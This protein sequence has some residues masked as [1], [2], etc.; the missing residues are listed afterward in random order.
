MDGSQL[1]F[2]RLDRPELEFL[3]YRWDTYS[4]LLILYVLGIGSPTHPIPVDCWQHWKL[5]L[6]KVGENTYVGGGPLFIHQ[7]SQAW[8]DLRDRVAARGRLTFW[9]R[10]RL[11]R[12]FG[13]RHSRTAGVFSSIWRANSQATP[14][15]CGAS[16]L[17]T[18]PMV[19]P[20]GEARRPH[21]RMDGTVVPS[22]AAGS[23]MFTPDICI[24]AMRTMLLK[25]GKSIYGRYG[26]ADAFNPGS[27]MDEPVRHR[28][29]CRNHVAQRGKPADGQRVAMVHAQSGTAAR[30]GDGGAGQPPS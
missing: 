26:F 7:Y 6:V 13:G 25:Y 3:P 30:A 17:P 29:R 28:N 16:P 12:E 20:T 9:S 24:P 23:L 18:A 10:H 27:G 4:E 22:A 15:P 14:R 8:V 21:P 11:F 1:L 19:T 2:A 5:P